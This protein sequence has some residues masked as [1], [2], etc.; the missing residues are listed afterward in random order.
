MAT[1]EYG[2]AIANIKEIRG[3]TCKSANQLS[4]M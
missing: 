1:S 2:K 3:A 4:V